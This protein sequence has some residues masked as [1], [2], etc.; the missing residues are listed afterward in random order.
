MLIKEHPKLFSNDWFK[1]WQWLL[2]FA[3]NSPIKGL[4][5][6]V[7]YRLGISLDRNILVNQLLEKSF[8][9]RTGENEFTE[10]FY[11]RNVFARSV[12]R[13]LLWLWNLIHKW[14]MNFANHFAPT[15]NL[16]FDTLTAYPDAHPET[17]T[18]DAFYE[19]GGSPYSTVR[20]SSA[21]SETNDYIPSIGVANY[22]SAPDYYVRRMIFLFNTQSLTANAVIS[23]ASVLLF[24]IYKEQANSGHSNVHIVSSN[25]TSTTEATDTDYSSLGSTSFSS[26]VYSS[27]NANGFNDFVMDANGINN[28]SKTGISKFGGRSNGDLNNSQPTSVNLLQFYSAENEDGTSRSPKLVITYTL[29]IPGNKYQV[30]I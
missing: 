21:S 13:E 27:I 30:I 20:D 8:R 1:I 2:L 28:I 6:E 16:G 19:N 7:R 17:T 14:D 25:P 10:T 4:R 18:F 26:I 12:H 23:N 22:L 5:E 3:V 15:L 9:I 29:P 24:G 11:G